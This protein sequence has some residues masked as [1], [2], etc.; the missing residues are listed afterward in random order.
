MEVRFPMAISGTTLDRIVAL[1]ATTFSKQLH[2]SSRFASLRIAVGL[3]ATMSLALIISG[4]GGG[5]Y[6]GGGIASTGRLFVRLNNISANEEGSEIVEF[7]LAMSVWVAAVFLIM[8]VS[9]ALYAAHFVANAAEVGARYASVRGSS[10]GSASCSSNPLDCA[11]SSSDIAS[12]IKNEVPA[13]ISAGSLTVST[14]WPGKT[15]SGATCDTVD[16]SNSPNCIVSVTV[17]YNF[18]FALSFIS[19]SNRLFSSS[20]KT[21]IVR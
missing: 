10:W 2:R 3:A 19:N 16:G 15:S 9:F 14:S 7:A 20:A 5:G 8:Y 17:S 12:Y 18:S 11:A 4:C 21:T 13:G 1:V 6:A